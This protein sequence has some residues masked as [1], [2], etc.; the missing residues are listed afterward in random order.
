[1]YSLFYFTIKAN[2]EREKNN[3]SFG[4]FSTNSFRKKSSAFLFS[5]SF[6]FLIIVLS[7]LLGVFT[8][9]LFASDSLRPIKS[10]NIKLLFPK[11]PKVFLTKSYTPDEENTV[12]LKMAYGSQKI[13]NPKEWSYIQKDAR[14]KKID[15]VMT[16]YPSDLDNWRVDF[17]NLIEKR[18]QNLTELDSNLLV[19]CT[20]KWNLILQDADS[21]SYHAKKR[22][23]GVFISYVDL[24]TQKHKNHYASVLTKC[25]GR[26]V[27]KIEGEKLTKIT[28]RNKDKWKKMLIVTDC[29]GSMMP[30][31]TEVF[32]WHMLK[33]NKNNVNQFAFFN[34]GE[35]GSQAIGKSGGIHM[36]KIK[37]HQ[38]IAS[39]LNY[40]NSLGVKNF[41]NPEND[42]EA[43]I[44][45]MDRAYNYDEVVL[46][47]DN[48]SSIR[49][50]KLVKQIKHPIRIVLCG[51]DMEN[52][53]HPDYLELAFLTKGSIHTVEKDIENFMR[54]DQGRII[55]IFDEKYQIQGDELVNVKEEKK[56]K[57]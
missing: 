20:I 28:K 38:K 7:I 34:D 18:L 22:D 35:T 42:L 48:N 26:N 25:Y 53:I 45:A 23:H 57:Y 51:L 15:V 9:N 24:P 17:E 32:L 11:T 36:V 55:P 49:D 8:S 19:D 43:I 31:G 1:M 27:A 6:K 46:I 40:V 29:S 4:S 50:F 10:G 37:D 21:T 41:D 39:A 2:E 54:D 5:R 33:Y 14:A 52:N 47:A 44:Y 3:S 56:I 12:H 30:Y 16:L 13:L